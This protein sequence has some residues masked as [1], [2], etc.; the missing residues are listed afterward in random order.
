MGPIASAIFKVV[1][2]LKGINALSD[3]RSI[4]ISDESFNELFLFHGKTYEFIFGFSKEDE[5]NGLKILSEA[6]PNSDVK[7]WREVKASLA[8]AIDMLSI[9]IYFTLTFISPLVKPD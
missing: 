8:Y 5:K 9:T 2:V 3:K 7:S 1:G 6:F 4:F